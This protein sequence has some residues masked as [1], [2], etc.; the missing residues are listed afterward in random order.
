MFTRIIAPSPEATIAAGIGFPIVCIGLVSGRFHAKRHMGSSILIDDWLTIPALV[1]TAAMGISLVVGVAYRG[2][3]YPTPLPPDPHHSL[4][5]IAPQTVLTRKIEHLL[6]LFHFP[7]L[8]CSKLSVLFFYRRVFC[9]PWRRFLHYFF[10]FLIAVCILWGIGFFISGFFICGTHFS[11]FWSN[12]MTLRRHCS[13]L[14]NQE[15]YMVTSDFVIDA[16]IFFIPIPLV[17]RL[18]LSLGRKFAVLVVF[19]FAAITVAV[20]IARMMIFL[21]AIHGLK[22]KYSSTGFDNQI[23][24][25]GLYWTTL[26]TGFSLISVCLPPLYTLLRKSCR[27]KCIRNGHFD[28]ENGIIVSEN[29]SNGPSDIISKPD[30]LVSPVMEAKNAE[31][32]QQQ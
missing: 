32:L 31:M 26:E 22:V 11:A 9:P 20:S 17:L 12:V 10:I 5:F 2:L 27:D 23:I 13:Q 3:G 6:L 14:H 29:S 25:A 15:V 16:V 28:E 24:T 19:L 4:T 30:E 1:F 18:K 21:Q 8:T 7:A